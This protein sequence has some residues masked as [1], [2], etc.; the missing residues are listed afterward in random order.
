VTGYGGNVPL[1]RGDKR[2]AESAG[3]RVGGVRGGRRGSFCFLVDMVVASLLQTAHY[4][5][6]V[7]FIT[8]QKWGEDKTAGTHDQASCRN[9]GAISGVGSWKSVGL[10]RMGGSSAIG[11]SASRRVIRKPDEFH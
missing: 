8:A 1:T 11:D 7:C 6:S 9:R 10:D 4:L 5:R 2:T 3:E